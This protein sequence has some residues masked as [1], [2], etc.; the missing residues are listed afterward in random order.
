MWS[1]AYEFGWVAILAI[2]FAYEMYAM[3]WGHHFYPMLTQVVVR[4][5]PKWITLPFV[6]WLFIH[7]L[8]RYLDPTYVKDLGTNHPFKGFI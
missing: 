8:V 3:I 6:G 5:V 4:Y 7:F 2:L 1:K